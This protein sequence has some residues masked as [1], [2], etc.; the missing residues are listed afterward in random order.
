MFWIRSQGGWRGYY[1]N[2]RAPT[3]R[4]MSGD[5]IGWRRIGWVRAVNKAKDGTNT[6]NDEVRIERRKKEGGR[7][8]SVEEMKRGRKRES[9]SESEKGGEEQEVTE[10]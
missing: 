7:S 4:E 10:S 9:E 8:G 2:G 5:V 3:D 6:G 1:S